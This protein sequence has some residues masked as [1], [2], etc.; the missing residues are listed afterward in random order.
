[1][2]TQ[3]AAAVIAVPHRAASS[4]DHPGDRRQKPIS[5]RPA[6]HHRPV[7]SAD[8]I[9]LPGLALT[10]EQPTI[11]PMIDDAAQQQRIDD[12]RRRRASVTIS[13]PS[14]MV[15]ISVTT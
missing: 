3:R 7:Y 4:A 13:A 9:F 6:A 2:P 12:R 11:E 15:A 10:I 8:M 14:S 5:D 1:M